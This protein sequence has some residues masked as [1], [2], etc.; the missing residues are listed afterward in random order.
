MAFAD[1]CITCEV[2]VESS[3][4]HVPSP[5]RHDTDVPWSS[6]DNIRPFPHSSLPPNYREY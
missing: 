1:C 3:A 5:Q 4:R 2:L 6:D